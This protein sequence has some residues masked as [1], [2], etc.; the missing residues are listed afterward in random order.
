MSGD[1]GDHSLDLPFEE[2]GAGPFT[3]QHV[4]MSGGLV[5]LASVVDVPGAGKKPALVF[6]FAR[7]DG[8]FYPAICLVADDDQIAK[9]RPLINEAIAAARRGAQL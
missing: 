7:P 2:G 9:I 5:V 1:L 3:D 4:H 6:R 8:V